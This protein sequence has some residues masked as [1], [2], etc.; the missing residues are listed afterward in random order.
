MT[1]ITNLADIERVYANW[2]NHCEQVLT[3]TLTG[4]MRKHDH[5][6]F[7]KDSDIPEFDMS[8]KSDGFTLAS[9]KVNHGETFDEKLDDYKMRVHSTKFAYVTLEMIAYVMNLDEFEIFIRLFCYLD[10]ES[11]KN[12]GGCKIKCRHETKKMRAWLA[13]NAAA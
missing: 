11:S 6:S 4:E 9:A 7:D 12:G 3:F 10:K 8:V 13:E 1:T 2:G 5:V